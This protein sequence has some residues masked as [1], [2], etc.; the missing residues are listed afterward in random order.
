MHVAFIYDLN[1]LRL[2]RQTQWII[3]FALNQEQNLQHASSASEL[4][5]AHTITAGHCNLSHSKYS[6]NIMHRDNYHPQLHWLD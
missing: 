1:V 4:I 2:Y 3:T 5:M 6:F